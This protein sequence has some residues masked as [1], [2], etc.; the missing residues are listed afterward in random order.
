M[1]RGWGIYPTLHV[2]FPMGSNKFKDEQITGDIADTYVST[3]VI[4]LMC[5]FLKQRREIKQKIMLT[6]P[7]LWVVSFAYYSSMND[8]QPKLYVSSFYI[9]TPI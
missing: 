9:S 6:F 1:I 3:F 5:W 7:L 8:K 2:S 4:L